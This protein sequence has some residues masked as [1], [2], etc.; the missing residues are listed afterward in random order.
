MV[1]AC[2]GVIPKEELKVP[3]LISGSRMCGGDPGYLG[4]LDIIHEWFPH[5]RG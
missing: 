5:V 1:P 4:I 2:A 3:I